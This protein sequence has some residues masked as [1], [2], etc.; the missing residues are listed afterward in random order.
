MC[1]APNDGIVELA[2][3]ASGAERVPSPPAD[4]LLSIIIYDGI[5]WI[6]YHS[7]QRQV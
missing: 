1:D 3:C 7:L 4:L 6:N 5:V 2:T